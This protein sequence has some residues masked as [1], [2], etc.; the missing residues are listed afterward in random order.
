[1]EAEDGRSFI[2]AVRSLTERPREGLIYH[3][4]LDDDGDPLWSDATADSAATDARKKDLGDRMKRMRD[5]DDGGD[6]KL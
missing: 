3:V 2:V 4:P 6:L 5:G 1:M